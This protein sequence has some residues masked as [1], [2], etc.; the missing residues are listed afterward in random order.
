MQQ[1]QLISNQNDIMRAEARA[2]EDDT[3]S[4]RM[5]SK[6]YFCH[7]CEKNYKKMMTVSDFEQNGI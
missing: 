4:Y 7:L 5:V 3:H 1:E 2:M 6:H